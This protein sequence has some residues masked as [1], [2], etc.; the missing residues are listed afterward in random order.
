MALKK[1][2]HL[3]PFPMLKKNQMKKVHPMKEQVVPH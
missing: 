2:L 1:L 3:K